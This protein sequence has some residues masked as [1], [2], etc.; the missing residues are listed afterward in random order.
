MR[1]LDKNQKNTVKVQENT[2]DIKRSLV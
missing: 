2:I 1:S